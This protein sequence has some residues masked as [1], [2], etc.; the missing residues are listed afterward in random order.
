MNI[1]QIEENLQHL[2]KNFSADE[3]IF[4]LLR[5]YGFKQATITLIKKGSRNL[6]KKDGQIVLKNKLFFQR[7]NGEDLHVTIDALRKDKA[8]FRHDPRFIIVTDCKTLLAIDTKTQDPLDI[9]VSALPRHYDFFLP[10]AGMEKA[11]AKSENPAD[12]KAAER[13]AKLYDEILKDNPFSTHEELHSLN[14]FLS[15]LLFCFFAEDTD[16]FPKGSFTGLIGSYTQNEGSDLG[17]LLDRLFKIL[18]TKERTDEPEY[19]K[20]FPYVNGGLFGETYTAPKFSR[21]SRR[22]MIECGELDWKEINPDIFGSMIQAVVHAD[23]RGGMGMHYT[24]VPNIMK[25][26]EPLFLNELHEEF[27]KNEDNKAKLQQL[28][29][30]LEHLRIFDPACG[31]GN[32]LIIAYKEIRKLEMQIFK[33]ISELSKEP[34]LAFSR[35]SLSQF[36]GIEL[37]DFAHEVAILSLWLAEHQMNVLFKETFGSAKPA[38]PLHEGGHIVCGNAT[39]L[40]WE[41]VCPKDEGAEIYILGN[42][43]Y[44]GSRHQEKIHKDDLEEVCS[45]LSSFKKLD[46]IACWFLKAGKFCCETNTR[47]AF[48]STNSICQGEQVELLWPPLFQMG[49]EIQFAYL[50]FKWSNNAKAKAGVTCVIIGISRKTNDDKLLFHDGICGKAKHINAY[51][52]A[53]HNLIVTKRSSPISELPKMESGNKATDGGYLI[54]S[55][56][57]QNKLVS[58]YPDSKKFLRRVIGAEEFINGSHRWCLWLDDVSLEEALSVPV[59]KERIRLVK[60]TRLSSRDEGAQKLANKPHQFR[61]MKSP[62]KISIIIPTVSSERRVYIPIGFLG[63]N[64]VVIAPNNVV[65]DPDPYVFGIIQS[66][67]HILWV[68]TTSGALES[69]I[70]YSSQLSYNTFPFPK[71]SVNQKEAITQ[72]VYNVLEERENYPEKAIADLYDPDKM[73][74]GLREAHRNLDLAVERCYRSKPFSSDEERLEYLFKL[75][76]EMTANEKEQ[77]NE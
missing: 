72:H 5:A 23:Q 63:E 20:A 62:R 75:Y 41:H 69:R 73:P 54:L 51:L 10:W 55:E 17:H 56:H 13:M 34:T 14:I 4:D 7:A 59:I 18:N 46:Y 2:L 65:Y 74:D 77:R 15:R 68:R 9:D 66:L 11:Q 50:P 67:I 70:R 31:S 36:Y 48:V 49:M 16:I 30:R 28:L 29:E 19:L 8:T 39:R 64:D 42:P 47:Y 45:S 43:P 12:V 44:L 21:R 58:D 52:T 33:R 57:E 76:E 32:F 40:D 3:F 22:M 38:L 71:I 26:I 24:S 60:E 1:A 53:G 35:I 25:V 37:D 27:E 6:S 61:E